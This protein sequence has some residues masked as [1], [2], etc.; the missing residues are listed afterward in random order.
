MDFRFREN[1]G[2]LTAERYGIL[3]EVTASG[4]ASGGAISVVWHRN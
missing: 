4:Q 2:N 1:D 3:R